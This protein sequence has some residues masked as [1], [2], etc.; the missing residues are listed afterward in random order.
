MLNPVQESLPR[1]E[2]AAQ[3][4]TVGRASL[5]LKPRG[6][7]RK[8]PNWLCGLSRL[9]LRKGRGGGELIWMVLSS[10]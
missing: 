5:S 7:P 6:G 4:D 8:P 10:K 3:V 2:V 1:G 9:S